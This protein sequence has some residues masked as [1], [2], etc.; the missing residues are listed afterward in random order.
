[1][2]KKVPCIRCT[3]DSGAR[4]ICIS[5]GGCRE[6]CGVAGWADMENTPSVHWV[7]CVC[8]CVCV[9][10]RVSVAVCVCASK[11]PGQCLA[12][13]ASLVRT[14]RVVWSSGTPLLTPNQDHC[15][16][17]QCA[18]V[19]VRVCVCVCVCV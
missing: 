17:Q 7:V 9:R 6:R 14:R 1:M 16:V 12:S 11:L 15:A 10:V 5:Y 19:C 2:E 13:P 8:V 4:W 3:L 18:C